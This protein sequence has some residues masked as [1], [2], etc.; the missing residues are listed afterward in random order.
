MQV[1][2]TLY[3]YAMLEETNKSYMINHLFKSKKRPIDETRGRWADQQLKM[4]VGIPAI[5]TDNIAVEET[6]DIKNVFNKYVENLPI[7]YS[8][9]MK[10]ISAD[11]REKI[12]QSLISNKRLPEPMRLRIKEIKNIKNPIMKKEPKDFNEKL[13]QFMTDPDELDEE[14]LE[15]L[16][17]NQGILLTSKVADMMTEHYDVDFSFRVATLE[18]VIESI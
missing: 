2:N 1:L 16:N 10:S 5:L 6:K 4:K 11:A 13:K 17:E 14:I 18:Q 12:V 7:R 3:T 9:Y 8:D 15:F